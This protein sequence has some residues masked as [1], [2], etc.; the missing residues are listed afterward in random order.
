MFYDI[1]PCQ[2]MSELLI[3]IDLTYHM[4]ISCT[5]L[6]VVCDG[7]YVMHEGLSVS[8]TMTT[9]MTHACHNDI[10]TQT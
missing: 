3:F 2:T 6:P 9:I 7:L 10:M 5:G 8:C 1:I 4:L